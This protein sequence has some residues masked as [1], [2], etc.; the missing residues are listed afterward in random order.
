MLN[1][2]FV[3]FLILRG[4]KKEEEKSTDLSSPWLATD[5][6]TAEQMA[7]EV[8]ENKQTN[9]QGASEV[10]H[11]FPY[12]K[13]HNMFIHVS[14]VLLWDE[15]VVTVQLHFFLFIYYFIYV[16]CPVCVPC[17]TIE[18]SWVIS[19]SISFISLKQNN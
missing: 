9:K 3:L 12:I 6:I 5:L 10:A 4:E 8:N 11:V 1:L 15:M 18:L 7:R 19:I 16:I 17:L 14:H 13:W 2:H